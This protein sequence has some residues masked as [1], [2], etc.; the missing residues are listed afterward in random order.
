[1][2]NTTHPTYYNIPQYSMQGGGGGEEPSIIELVLAG[3]TAIIF[4]LSVLGGFT[5]IQTRNIARISLRRQQNTESWP[6]NDYTDN[7]ESVTTEPISR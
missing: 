5:Q 3:L 6:L 4:L 1:M 2:D 7:L